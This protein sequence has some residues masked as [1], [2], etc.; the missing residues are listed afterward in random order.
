MWIHILWVLEMKLEWFSPLETE[1][2]YVARQWHFA[3]KYA[4]V[5]IDELVIEET[6]IWR[7]E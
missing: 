5:V 4:S 2:D 1:L 7:Y 6:E 3:I